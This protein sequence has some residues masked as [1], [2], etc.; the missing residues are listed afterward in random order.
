MLQLC[1]QVKNTAVMCLHRDTEMFPALSVTI[2][3]KEKKDA[4][5]KREKI[6]LKI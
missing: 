1:G 4:F 2:S 5:K 6:R 3:I